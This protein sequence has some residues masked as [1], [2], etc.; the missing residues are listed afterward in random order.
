MRQSGK[1]IRMFSRIAETPVSIRIRFMG[2]VFLLV[3]ILFLLVIMMLYLTGTLT[4]GQKE[5]GEY[6]AQSLRR[7]KADVEL[8]FGRTSMQAIDLSET[9]SSSIENYLSDYDI[10]PS[11]L[12][13]HPEI[14]EEL[15]DD[16]FER[17]L[18]S[19]EKSGTSG[20]FII[21]DATVN[22][23][24][25]N[26]SMSRSALYVRNMEPNAVSAGTPNMT[27]LHGFPDIARQRGYSLNSIWS[28]EFELS[29]MPEYE[30]I[31]IASRDES[32]LRRL[33]LWSQSRQLLGSNEDIMLCIVPLIDENG[34]FFGVC[35]FEVSGM[36]FKLRYSPDTTTY[37]RVTSLIC[38]VEGDNF[39]MVGK[40]LCGGDDNSIR[41]I[42]SNAQSDPSKTAMRAVK[43]A[44]SVHIYRFASSDQAI[45]ESLRNRYFV[46]LHETVTLLPSDSV[47]KD[48]TFSLM[49]LMPES[50][51]SNMLGKNN[52]KFVS[53][54]ALFILAGGLMA[55]LMSRKFAAPILNDLSKLAAGGDGE[56]ED[57]MNTPEIM[58]ILAQIRTRHPKKLVSDAPDELFDDFLAKIRRLTPTEKQIVLRFL[59]EKSTHEVLAEMF[60]SA[61]TLKTHNSHIYAKLDVV[62]R[63]EL[64]LYFRLI[65]KTGRLDDLRKALSHS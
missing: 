63:D 22:P 65:E 19:L 17:L 57:P 34:Q 29:M 53:L 49:L 43:N 54:C 9:V 36:L 16:Q 64:Q 21:L 27:M 11:D 24:L 4:A 56:D 38:P 46:G 51:Y 26:A 20:A 37:K 1:D 10:H 5:S 59:E 48:R 32:T 58:A 50:E 14:L 31:R 30:E 45:T 39:L 42:L 7:T 44:L 3:S 41:T 15:L 23:S 62:S 40:S 33:Y 28:M 61:S 60:I 13:S 8:D 35:G 18:F 47:F 55:V 12:K 52:I 2:F 6:F 25:E